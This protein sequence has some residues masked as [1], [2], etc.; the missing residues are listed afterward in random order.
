MRTYLG[1]LVNVRVVWYEGIVCF[2]LKLT[3]IKKVPVMV[4]T[5]LDTQQ[6][7]LGN[8]SKLRGSLEWATRIGIR[9]LKSRQY[10]CADTH[11]LSGDLESALGQILAVL[12]VLHPRTVY[13]NPV[14]RQPRIVK[15]G[16]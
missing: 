7:T 11:A 8:A 15:S 6:L 13:V 1:A 3:S 14:L 9:A 4:Q 10:G 12:S 5:A 16:A 2:A